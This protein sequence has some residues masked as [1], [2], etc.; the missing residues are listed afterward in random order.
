MRAKTPRSINAALRYSRADR[1]LVV[2]ILWFCVRDSHEGGQ[3]CQ[4]P[5]SSQKFAMRDRE[6]RMRK[7][8]IMYQY[9]LFFNANDYQGMQTL[10]VSVT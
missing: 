7:S 2:F 9:R 10:R 6:G 8:G 1:Q 5:P 3:W 4:L